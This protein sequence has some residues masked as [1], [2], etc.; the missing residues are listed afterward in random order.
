[1]LILYIAKKT[2]KKSDTGA[3]Y[4]TMCALCTVCQQMRLQMYGLTACFVALYTFVVLLPAVK[5]Q[6][7]LQIYNFTEWFAA[8]W[9]KMHLYPTVCQQVS[10][11]MSSKS[12]WFVAF[13]T[14]VM[15]NISDVLLVLFCW[16]SWMN[17]L[18]QMLSNLVSAWK[19][20]IYSFT[21][22]MLYL[23]YY[24]RTEH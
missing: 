13:S 1:M 18:T 10:L 2:P 23:Q 24:W 8:N 17:Q 19:F 16:Q 4:W 9:T 21:L 20:C 6:V 15:L 3:S 22:Y 5:E 7:P 14:R 12:E 11:Q